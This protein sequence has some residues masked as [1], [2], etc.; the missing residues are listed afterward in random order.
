MANRTRKLDLA[1]VRRSRAGFTGAVTKA[2][3]KLT[4]MKSDEPEEI[5]ALNSREVERLMGSIT[6]SETGFLQTLEDAQQFLPTDDGEEAFTT[7]EDLAMDNF[8]ETISSARDEGS[9]LLALK[10]VLIGLADFS[11]DSVTIQESLDNNPD[12]N[13]STPL[14]DLKILFMKLKEEWKGANLPATHSLKAELD[15]CRKTINSLEI[16]VA[17]VKDR[18]DSHSVASST[19]TSSFSSSNR[20]CYNTLADL[21]TIKVPTF[22]GN[23]LEWNTF[24]AAFRATIDSRTELSNTQKLQ[25]LRQAVE[26]PDLQ[27]LLHSPTESEDMY[28][29]VIAE[30]KDRFNKTREIHAHLADSLIKLSTPKQT[31]IDLRRM[32]DSVKRTIDSLKHTEH[33][34]LDAFLS[35][36]VY[37]ILP[38]RLQTLWDQHTKKDKGVPPVL[39]LLKFLKE[40]AETLPSVITPPSDKPSDSS[41]K[42]NPRQSDKKSGYHNPR[43]KGSVYSVSSAPTSGSTSTSTNYKWE[44]TLC[45]PEKHPLHACPKWAAF[46]LAEKTTHI[47]SK[48]LCSNCLA[49]GHSTS[50]CKSTYRC[51]ECG[52]PH[53]TSIH[54]HSVENTTAPIHS[55]SV[56]GHQVP[57][58]LKTTAQVLLLG[59]TGKTLKAR[60]LLDS[61]AGICLVSK[62]VTQLLDLPLDPSTLQ[63]STLQRAPCNNSDYVTS[64]IVSP[65]LNR[66]IQ[67]LCK[68]AVLQQVTCDLPPH[69]IEPVTD[70]PHLMGLQLAD[71]S[72]HV[73]SQIDILLGT[74]LFPQ[75]MTQQLTRAGAASDPMAQATIFGWAL[76]GP[77]KLKTL[78]AHP[79]STPHN[80]MPTS[81]LERPTIHHFNPTLLPKPRTDVSSSLGS[82]DQLHSLYTTCSSSNSSALQPELLQPT[83]SDL[84]TSLKKLEMQ[85]DEDSLLQH[86]HPTLQADLQLELLSHPR[87]DK[88]TVSNPVVFIS[89]ECRTKDTSSQTSTARTSDDNSQE[90]VSM[91]HA[92]QTLTTS[93]RSLTDG[94]TTPSELPPSR[95]QSLVLPSIH[96]ILGKVIIPQATEALQQDL[97][98]KLSRGEFSSYKWKDKIHPALQKSSTALQK[99][100]RENA[101]STHKPAHS[102]Q[103]HAASL[104]TEKLDTFNL[105]RLLLCDPQS[106][107]NTQLLINNQMLTDLFNVDTNNLLKTPAKDWHFWID[108]SIYLS[109][110]Q[111][112]VA[113]NH[114]ISIMQATRSSTWTPG[115]TASI[116]KQPPKKGLLEEQHINLI[117]SNPL[118]AENL[119]KHPQPL[120][121]ATRSTGFL[122]FMRLYIFFMMCLHICNRP[123]QYH[124]S[125]HH[126]FKLDEQH[127]PSNHCFLLQSSM[128]FYLQ[129]MLKFYLLYRPAHST[130]EP[131]LPLPPGGCLGRNQ[132]ANQ[133]TQ[134]LPPSAVIPASPDVYQGT[135]TATMLETL[136]PP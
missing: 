68:P 36:L 60:A 83:G 61:G 29:S 2:L 108:Y 98:N 64:L 82:Y 18:S 39:L 76:C 92:E 43:G 85:P 13:Q 103:H 1:T 91:D 127:H 122:L 52:Q 74:D 128:A 102:N 12:C 45:R 57:D 75:I 40:H 5:Q 41:P 106:P 51:R 97:R 90:P 46:S 100:S 132:P 111:S 30:L 62:K 58:A 77:V 84:V 121:P 130:K 72:Y 135:K 19:S 26:D 6:R 16:T 123:L 70:L 115:P 42:K 114:S 113:N 124:Y 22:T 126:L 81:S 65:L 118:T 11:N 116:P 23:I 136:Q 8:Q 66:E 59:P 73:P 35:S 4:H 54:S 34:N 117:P 9:R 96:N 120:Q 24:W 38:Q 10:S 94:F 101:L 56:K 49:G 14:Q 88:L 133:T 105:T 27:A 21:P 112:S 7:E 17:A 78:S 107:I 31:R 55:T 80:L 89:V 79:S 44:C 3:D 129:P 134:P 47:N 32:V 20:V 95:T 104:I 87:T 37:L 33:Y 25:Y 109:W 53:H 119:C 110:L 67:V 63:L 71:P 86:P 69:P 15:A 125:I 48:S 28:V 99:P 50:S 131:S 93:N